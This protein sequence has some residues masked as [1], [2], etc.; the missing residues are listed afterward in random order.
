MP[1]L[2]HQAGP[3]LLPTS[4]LDRRRFIITDRT[5]PI[6]ARQ[7][8]LAPS[9]NPV[10]VDLL[11]LVRAAGKVAKHVV[12]DIL[13]GFDF[14]LLVLAVKALEEED[15]GGSLGFV[16]PFGRHGEDVVIESGSG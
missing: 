1:D 10:P 4:R 13:A 14:A 16:P 15:A 3:D 2:H 6:T 5:R 12:E 7:E 9:T 11:G 8:F